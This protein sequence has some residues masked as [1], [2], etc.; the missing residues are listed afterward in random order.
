M[1]SLNKDGSLQF[2]KVCVAEQIITI[3]DL[4]AI[5]YIFFFNSDKVH[6][7]KGNDNSA[8]TWVLPNSLI[9]LFKLW[10]PLLPGHHLVN[11]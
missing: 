4:N 3:I 8:G 5:R 2:V 1:T 9:R 6:F 7:K 11:G 10:T